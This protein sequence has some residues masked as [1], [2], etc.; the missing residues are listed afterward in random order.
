MLSGRWSCG[1]GLERKVS[2]CSP[3]CLGD[4]VLLRQPGSEGKEDVPGGAGRFSWDVISDYAGARFALNCYL[5]VQSAG[6]P[7]S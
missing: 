4:R 1:R 2:A 7:V 6:G 5:Y 3:P